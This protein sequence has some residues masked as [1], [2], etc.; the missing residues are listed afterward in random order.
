LKAC[1]RA[2]VN[3]C[4]LMDGWTG[5]YPGGWMNLSKPFPVNNDILSKPALLVGP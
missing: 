4:M 1:V 2:C 5:G 3:V